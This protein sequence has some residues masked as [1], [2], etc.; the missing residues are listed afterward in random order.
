MNNGTIDL[1]RN[2]FIATLVINR[3]AKLNA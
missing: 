1:Q 2:G 3:P